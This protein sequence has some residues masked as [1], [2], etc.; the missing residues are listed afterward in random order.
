MTALVSR[1]RRRTAL[2][3]AAT[4]LIVVGAGTLGVVGAF[5]LRDY[6]AATNAQ[7]DIPVQRLPVTPVGLF[8][9]V[10]DSDQLTSTTVFVLAPS[11]QRGGSIVSVP[12][13]AD[14]SSG[15]GEQR[16][17]LQ[18][19][20]REGGVEALVAGVESALGITI[21]HA[22]VAD[23]GDAGGVLLSLGPLDVDL[24]DDVRVTDDDGRTTTLFERGP[25]TL[26]TAQAVRVLTASA[27]DGTEQQRRPNIE[28]LWGAVSAAIGGGVQG[29]VVPDPVVDFDG[30][31]ASL[32]SGPTGARGLSAAP[33]TD[34][35]NPDGLDV[36]RVDLAEAALVFG[37]IAPA[38]VSAVR[39][40][41]S[42][43]IEAPPGYDDKVQ[44]TIAILMFFG[45]N[46]VSVDLASPTRPVTEM[47]VFDKR[48]EGDIGSTNDLIG[49]FVVVDPTVRIE[50]IDV[51]IRL[52]ANFLDDPLL[53]PGNPAPLPG[54][55]DSPD[56]TG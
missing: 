5:G 38:S 31:V 3:L 8:A 49:D 24:P 26:T 50:G 41:L 22:R 7:S 55:D 18:D 47:V 17:S 45:G 36:E 10:D 23:P 13:N 39:P 19:A 52:G 33:F 40:W 35:L 44:R 51:T 54:S 15:V 9:T 32:F 20:Y 25:Q 14:V 12:V 48:V 37:S 1:R 6:T 30:L 46:I 2:M 42:I 21:D 27:D 53:P 4:L 43:R 16:V 34:D 11:G 28:A 29:L 56:T